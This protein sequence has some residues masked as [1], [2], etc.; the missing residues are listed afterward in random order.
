[1]RVEIRCEG[2]TPYFDKIAH[3]CFRL[4]AP[5]GSLDTVKALTGTPVNYL[6]TVNFR[7]FRQIIDRLGGA[8]IDVD[9]RYFNDR[10]GPS[11]YAKINL[12]PGYQRLTGRQALDYVRYRHT[13]WTSTAS[14]ASSSS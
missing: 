10:G 13:D 6:I 7:G 8:W 4:W 1:M 9:R 3:A 12:R 14:R 5:Q 11:G 2:R